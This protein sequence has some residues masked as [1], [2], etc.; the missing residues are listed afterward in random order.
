MTKPLLLLLGPN[1]QP[2]TNS[3]S[4]IRVT[5]QAEAQDPTFESVDLVEAPF[6]WW[7][8]LEAA[9]GAIVDH[10]PSV[11]LLI[12]TDPDARIV[13]VAGGARNRASPER[14][15]SGHCWPGRALSPGGAQYLPATL[16]GDPLLE[17]LRGSQCPA[18]RVGHPGLGV[19]N[20]CFYGLLASAGPVRIGCLHVP[21]SLESARRFNFA[22]PSCYNRAMLLAAVRACLDG[23]Q[24]AITQC[25]GAYAARQGPG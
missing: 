11:V 13:R 22:T 16:P 4:E 9:R 21:V 24:H 5:M 15:A 18:E 17:A 6:K 12:A 20:R 23:A 1:A 19:A 10:Q 25:L 2:V 14:D 3:A 8:G 7:D